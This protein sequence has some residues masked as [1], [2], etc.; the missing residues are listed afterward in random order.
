MILRPNKDKVLSKF[1]LYQVLSPLIQENQIQRLS[2]GSASPHL[3]IG[4]MRRFRFRVPPLAEQHRIV[5]HLDG[6]HREVD[7][8]KRL[9]AESAAEL[10]AVLP[11]VLD[12]V[13][14][15]GS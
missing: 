14:K 15:M 2:K 6:L 1:F 12:R 4:A 11:T 9:Q 7:A 5:A 10:D 8:L 13:F 3:N